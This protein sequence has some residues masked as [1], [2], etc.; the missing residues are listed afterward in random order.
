MIQTRRAERGW[1]SP[2]TFPCVEANVVMITARR[3]ERRLTTESL[4]QFE[5]KNVAVEL[6]RPLQIGHLQVNVP[7]AH[8]RVNGCVWHCRDEHNDETTIPESCVA[9]ASCERTKQP[10]RS[11]HL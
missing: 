8:S 11:G 10:Q 1:T 6:Q 2:G 7:D 5:S 4:L 3:N 9:T